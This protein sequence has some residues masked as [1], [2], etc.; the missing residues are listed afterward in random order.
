MSVW[1]EF[2]D[3]RDSMHCGG[4]KPVEWREAEIGA[5]YEMYDAIYDKVV[6]TVKCTEANKGE[7]ERSLNDSTN[8]IWWYRKAV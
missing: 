1:S 5:K 7:I 6:K 8:D 2:E 3:W 4:E